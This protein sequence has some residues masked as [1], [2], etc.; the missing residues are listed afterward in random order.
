MFGLLLSI[1]K[2]LGSTPLVGQRRRAYG[3][4]V[5]GEEERVSKKS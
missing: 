3:E 2:T 4:H 5:R 1:C